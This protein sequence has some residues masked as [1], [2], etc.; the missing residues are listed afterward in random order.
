MSRFGGTFEAIQQQGVPT[1]AAKL[2]NERSLP[3][4]AA[5]ASCLQ[6]RPL[7]PS[8]TANNR[9]VPAHLRNPGTRPNVTRSAAEKRHA[10]ANNKRAGTVMRCK[11]S[12]ANGKSVRAR[13]INPTKRGPKLS[14]QRGQTP[15]WRRAGRR[16]HLQ[17]PIRSIC[18]LVS[19]TPGSIWPRNHHREVF[20]PRASNHG[21]RRRAPGSLHAA[22]QRPPTMHPSPG[23]RRRGLLRATSH[24]RLRG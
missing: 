15:L 9:R 23:Q 12:R 20:R 8:S 19:A 4:A 5:H 1:E 10:S 22:S 21:Y 24:T 3:R 17:E 7:A 16:Q 2:P 11:H 18:A 6:R 14:V 13:R